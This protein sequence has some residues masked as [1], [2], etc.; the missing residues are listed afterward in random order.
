MICVIATIEVAAGRRE[1]LLALFQGVM[2]KVRAEQGCIDYGAMI[3]VRSSLAA[4]GPVR[5]N[6]VIIV[7]RWESLA[8]L[9][10]HSEDPAHGRVFP[11]SRGL[12]VELEPASPSAGLTRV[13]HRW[14][15]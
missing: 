11:A 8:A 14:L 15:S 9:Q 7:E 13:V 12:A 6:A 10:A 2:P 5:D 3:D 1:E 4:Q